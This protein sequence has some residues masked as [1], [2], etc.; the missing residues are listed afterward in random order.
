MDT[1][2]I[3]ALFLWILCCVFTLCLAIFFFR[4]FRKAKI[5]ISVLG[6]PL[7][8]YLSFWC[9]ILYYFPRPLAKVAYHYIYK[10]YTALKVQGVY[11]LDPDASA[12]PDENYFQE[13]TVNDSVYYNDRFL[14][15][16]NGKFYKSPGLKQYLN[17][18]E[19]EY[20]TDEETFP[21]SRLTQDDTIEV[22]QTLSMSLKGE[23]RLTPGFL[24]KL[25]GSGRWDPQPYGETGLPELTLWFDA[26]KRNGTSLGRKAIYKNDALYIEG[27]VFKKK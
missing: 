18:T 24:P 12:I 7:I 26:D 25:Q 13:L 5:I 21:L 15:K 11:Q 6:I 10:P 3:L 27:L 20:H 8:M 1:I 16:L 23:V 4:N 2:Q 14:I 22:K 9:W 19:F 17:E